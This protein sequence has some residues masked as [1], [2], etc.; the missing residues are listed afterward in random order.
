MDRTVSCLGDPEVVNADQSQ[1]VE[2]VWRDPVIK[3][4]QR[5]EIWQLVPI[6]AES[7]ADIFIA[8]R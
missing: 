4:G 1:P 5:K 2:L 6:K 8:D 7:C 3:A